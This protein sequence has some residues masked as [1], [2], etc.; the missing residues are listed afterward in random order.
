MSE[1]RIYPSIDVRRSW[2][3][4]EELLLGSDILS[5]SWRVRRMLD[6][7]NN[8]DEA[9]G[10]LLDR[11]KKTKDNKEFLAKLHEEI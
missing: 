1:K 11:M 9:I 6:A 8:D 4:N 10:V 5:Q 2:T 7:I 3:R